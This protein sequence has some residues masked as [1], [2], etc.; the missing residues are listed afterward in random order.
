MIYSIGCWLLVAGFWSMR[1]F[2]QQPAT[3][4]QQPSTYFFLS[5]ML[6]TRWLVRFMIE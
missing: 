1:R 6:T 2:H 5:S 4:N 3:H